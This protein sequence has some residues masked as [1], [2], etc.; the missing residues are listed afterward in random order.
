W[1][2]GW[3][4]ILLPR[5]RRRL[6]VEGAFRG[7]AAQFDY[8]RL[9]LPRRY[10]NYLDQPERAAARD[11][12]PRDVSRGH[13]GRTREEVAGAHAPRRPR[14]RNLWGSRSREGI[15]GRGSELIRKTEDHREVGL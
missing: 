12:H 7:P 10:A 14:C 9:V 3:A 4:P 11:P 1:G 8:R 15:E 5:L 2:G 13:S 6:K